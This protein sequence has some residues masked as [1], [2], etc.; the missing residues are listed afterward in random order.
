MIVKRPLLYIPVEVKSREFYAKYY[1]GYICS[2]HGFDVII[3][4][5]NVLNSFILDMPPGIYFGLGAFENFYPF[6][7]EL[8]S[9]GFLIAI[10]EE[11]GLVTYSDDMYIDMRVSQR[12]LSVIDHI[13]CWGDENKSILSKVYPEYSSKLFST[14]SPRFD[15]LKSPLAEIYS[16]ES[17]YIHAHYQSYF[18]CC[19]CFSSIN[20]FDKNL[21]YLQSLID[22]KTLRTQNSIDNFLRYQKVKSITLDTYLESIRSVALNFPDR[23]IVIRPHPSENTEIYSSLASEFPNVFVETRFSVH[24]WILHCSALIHHYCTTSIEAL[25]ADIPRYAIRPVSDPA[26][27]K[28]T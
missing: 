16:Q 25:C 27:E 8:K 3:A 11:E 19:T 22:K 7:K 10:N 26:S 15:L 20:H 28:E 12:S 24:P 2:L 23:T 17:S 13:Y 5:K 21:D 9:R 1:L 18:L 4:N 14:G 6:Y